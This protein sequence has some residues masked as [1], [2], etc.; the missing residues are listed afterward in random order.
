MSCQFVLAPF[1]SIEMKKNLICFGQAK[2]SRPPI[3]LRLGTNSVDVFLPIADCFD[4][5]PA[6]PAFFGTRD[7]L[8][9]FYMVNFAFSGHLPLPFN[10]WASRGIF[11][12]ACIQPVLSIILIQSHYFHIPSACLHLDPVTAYVA[13]HVS[14]ACAFAFGASSRHGFT[15]CLPVFFS[16]HM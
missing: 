11:T 12:H 3:L 2:S 4:L 6:P 10:F 8:E 13:F 14:V 16:L 9:I 1:P 5:G 15:F 7:C